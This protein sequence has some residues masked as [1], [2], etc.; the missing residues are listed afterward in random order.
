MRKYQFHFC[1]E[2]A[3]YDAFK[4]F[5]ASVLADCFYK[6]FFFISGT[7]VKKN[8]NQSLFFSHI[9][10]Y[11]V[12]VCFRLY[13]GEA[14]FLEIHGAYCYINV[15]ENSCMKKTVRTFLKLFGRRTFHAEYPINTP[16]D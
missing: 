12:C 15:F 5:M 16:L 4:Q 13:L 6:L 10:S 9:H 11:C 7:F 8:Q 14:K 3:A 2:M 1:N